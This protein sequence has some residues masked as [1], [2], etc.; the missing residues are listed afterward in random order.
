[1]PGTSPSSPWLLLAESLG[2]TC[3]I[4]A[5][6]LFKINPC[7]VALN[8]VVLQQH[9]PAT[10]PLFC[11]SFLPNPASKSFSRWGR[12]PPPQWSA[13]VSPFAWC[14]RLT[15]ASL[16]GHHPFW[17]WRWHCRGHWAQHR[18]GSKALRDHCV[19]F[20]GEGEWWWKCHFQSRAGF[21]QTQGA[22]PTPENLNAYLGVR[23]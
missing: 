7:R 13:T 19:A 6:F 16:L 14:W 20:A 17:P 8:P 21:R 9:S 2:T 10:S 1:M 18:G 5:F 22:E 4:R 15:T 3:I 23:A 12:K 11:H